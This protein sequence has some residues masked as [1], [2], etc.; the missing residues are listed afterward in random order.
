MCVIDM[1]L[2]LLAIVLKRLL[3]DLLLFRVTFGVIFDEMGKIGDC[4]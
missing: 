1:A 3:G 2:G 4:L